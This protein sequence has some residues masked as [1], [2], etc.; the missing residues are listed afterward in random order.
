MSKPKK[1]KCVPKEKSIIKQMEGF[2]MKMV[3]KKLLVG[4]LIVMMSVGMV[5]IQADA[6]TVITD[7][8]S[9]IAAGYTFYV[10]ESG[11]TTELGTMY[12]TKDSEKVSNTFTASKYC[13]SVTVYVSDTSY[14]TLNQKTLHMLYS[15]DSVSINKTV[16]KPT[17]VYGKCSVTY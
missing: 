7:V 6:A 16:E 2:T 11:S 3:S 8:H 13:K 9:C 5:S 12:L 17:I 14:L 4:I 1:S 15:G 10:R